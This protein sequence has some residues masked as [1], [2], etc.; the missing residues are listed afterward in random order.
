[1]EELKTAQELLNEVKILSNGL[2]ETIDSLQNR[3]NDKTLRYED[4]PDYLTIEELKGWL[5]LGTNKLYA[6]ANK[7][8]F[9]T[10]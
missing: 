3:C 9:P 10:I 4:L 2:R 8:G 5:P 6:L 7:P 1:M